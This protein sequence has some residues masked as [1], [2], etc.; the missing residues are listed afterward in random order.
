MERENSPYDELF[1]P[2]VNGRARHLYATERIL[3]ASYVNEHGHDWIVTKRDI[4][5]LIGRNQ[6]FVDRAIHR[7]RSAKLIAT[8]TVCDPRTNAA[9]AGAYR[10]THAGIVCVLSLTERLCDAQGRPRA[11]ADADVRTLEQ[12]R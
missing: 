12:H 1:V 4:A 6:K 7:L 5:R 8:R 11:L 2:G 10:L 9:V 3:V